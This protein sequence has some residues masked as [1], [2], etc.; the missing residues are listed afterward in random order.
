MT[1]GIYNYSEIGR[2]KKV[3][4]HRPGAELEALTPDTL[5]DMLFE[6]IPF[7]RVAQQEH[8]KFAELLKENGVE[9]VYYVDEAA[10]AMENE[11]VRKQFI[12]EFLKLSRINSVGLSSAIT[13]YLM[14]FRDNSGYFYEYDCKDIL[15]LVPL[16]NDKRC[17]T[18]AYI[19]DSKII[20]PLIQ[21][22][23][24]GIDRVVP[25]GKTMDF[26][27]IWDGYNLPSLLT[28]TIVMG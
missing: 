14:D 13:D 7:L 12:Q 19:G 25:M 22:G 24:K 9:V 15:D 21:S 8:D 23:V 2:L 10:R 5:G 28:R 26:D 1:K 3:L 6:D 16:C 4:L 17:Q 18:I 27:L 11:E 20:L